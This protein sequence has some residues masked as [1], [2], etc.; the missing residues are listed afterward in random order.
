MH[1]TIKITINKYIKLAG[2]ISTN[3]NSGFLAELVGDSGGKASPRK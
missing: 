1:A 3:T 2:Q